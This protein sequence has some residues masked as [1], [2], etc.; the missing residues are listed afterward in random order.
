MGR[1]RVRALITHR[2]RSGFRVLDRTEEVIR[3]I[4]DI[5]MDNPGIR[6]VT[7][8]TGQ[9][10]ALNAFGSNFASMFINLKDF[11]DRGSCWP[12]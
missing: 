6:H 7:G 2:S 3:Q 4:E 9:S 12:V 10:F 5:C 11:G 8:I 1:E